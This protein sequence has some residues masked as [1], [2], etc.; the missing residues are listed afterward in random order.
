L[1]WNRRSTGSWY[2]TS[3]SG[4]QREA[5][6]RRVGTV[7]RE[8]ARDAEARAAVGAVDERVSVATIGRVVELAEAVVAHGD[9]GRDERA[10]G[11]LGVAVDDVELALPH[12]HDRFRLDGVDAGERGPLDDESAL[13]RGDS[14]RIPLHLDEHAIGVVPDVPAELQGVAKRWT[15]GRKPTPCTTTAHAD[16]VANGARVDRGRRHAGRPSVTAASR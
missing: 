4:T 12:R 13:E 9:V 8:P 3:H 14:G 11:R 7:V 16:P 6:H 1:A 15:N 10:T 2:W 5:R